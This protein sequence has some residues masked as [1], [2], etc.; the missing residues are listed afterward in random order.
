MNNRDYR[1]CAPDEYYHIFNRGNAKQN[2]FLDTQDY[3]FFLLRLDQNLYPDKD[4]RIFRSSP[5]PENAFSLINFC[6][7]PNHYHLLIKQNKEIP[8][9][10]LISRICTSYS[11]YFN[12][13]YERVGHV[14]QDQFKQVNVDNN[15]YLLWLSA[16]I[17][18][19]PSVAGLIKNPADYKWSSFKL[20]G[21]SKS[22]IKD[23]EIILEQFKNLNDYHKFVNSS[24]NLIKEKKEIEHLLLD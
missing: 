8:V 14:F 22:L 2:I 21:D 13:K 15:D 20:M 3:Q 9:S 10:K 19:N 18:Q 4:K 11:K 16:Y 6:L 7:M 1:K 17:H 12:K 23:Y 24:F 5:L